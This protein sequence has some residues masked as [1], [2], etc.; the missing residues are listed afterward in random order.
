MSKTQ[1]HTG[2]QRVLA[3][4]ESP[5]LL[6]ISL[7]HFIQTCFTFLIPLNFFL[8][9]EIFLRTENSTLVYLYPK[10]SAQLFTTQFCLIYV[11]A[12]LFPGGFRKN[13]NS[14]CARIGP[15]PNSGKFECSYSK[16]HN[17]LIWQNMWFFRGGFRSNAYFQLKSKKCSR[18]NKYF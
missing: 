4:L 5:V 14:W 16:N 8:K 17:V 18:S 13:T 12:P 2:Y 7:R 15:P 6:Q 3:F 9:K 1:L 11:T 10:S